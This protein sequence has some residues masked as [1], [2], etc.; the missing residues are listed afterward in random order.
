M[1]LGFTKYMCK[2]VHD[3][4]IEALRR[5]D[6]LVIRSSDNNLGWN[7]E[8]I[9]KAWTGLGYTTEYREA[10]KAGLM[11]PIHETPPPKIN[12]W[13]GLTEEGAKIILAWH[14]QGH[15][16]GD[17]YELKTRPRQ[18]HKDLGDNK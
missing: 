17:G 6:A 14:E 4:M 9:Q 16:C 15:N 10:V 18:L 7:I 13:W 8:D 12:G 3:V 1:M 5:Y 2:P 11:R